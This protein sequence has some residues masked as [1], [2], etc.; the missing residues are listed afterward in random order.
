MAGVYLVAVSP[1]QSEKKEKKREK[2]FLDYFIIF[3]IIFLLFCFIYFSFKT[4]ELFGPQIKALA[5]RLAEKQLSTFDCLV[6]V[7]ILPSFV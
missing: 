2:G 5:I 6:T 1:I 7:Q 3:K 4:S